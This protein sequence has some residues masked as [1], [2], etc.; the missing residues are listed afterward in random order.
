MNLELLKEKR[1]LGTQADL[2]LRIKEHIRNKSKNELVAA[3]K[4]GM[5]CAFKEIGLSSG[6]SLPG[7]STM[8][9]EIGV[10]HVT[11][12]KALK[13]LEEKGVVQQIHGKG[14]FLRQDF[15][16]NA[17]I[18][19]TV[20]VLL[21]HL[22]DNYSDIVDAVGAEW[23]SEDVKICFENVSWRESGDPDKRIRRIMDIMKINDLIGIICSPAIHPAQ[24]IKEIEFYRHVSENSVPVVFIDRAMDVEGISSVGFDDEWGMEKIFDHVWENNFRDIYYIYPDAISVNV[25]SEERS[26]GFKEAAARHG[27]S[28]D[29]RF[30]SLQETENKRYTE[31]LVRLL[32]EQAQG[33]AAFVCGNERA[34]LLIKEQADA[35]T[36]PERKVLVTG[37]DRIEGV[38]YKGQDFPS[39]SRS[40]SLLGSSAAKLLRKMI[41]SRREGKLL[42]EN[43][44]LKPEIIL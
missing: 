42:R 43:I 2:S 35:Q 38:N 34:A 7:N 26:N 37:Y 12:R 14:T 8:A 41:K 10:S 19:G 9:R 40:R 18:N 4:D 16:K 39:S 22:N 44:T 25:R 17:R 28:V 15:E 27:Y 30:Y 21:P 24:L 6:S 13:D 11:L 32:L 31:M 20:A 5:L 23:A 1:A 29:G 33:D 36:G 3:L